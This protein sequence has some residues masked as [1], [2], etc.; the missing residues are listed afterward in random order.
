[1]GLLRFLWV[2]IL[3]ETCCGFLPQTAKR[4]LPNTLPLQRIRLASAANDSSARA[5]TTAWSQRQEQQGHARLELPLDIASQFKILTC[6][7]MSCA[8]KRTQLGLDEYSTFSAF[9]TRAQERAPTL[10]VEECPCLGRCRA[11]PCVAVEHEDYEGPVSL[12]GMT[13]T[14]FSNRVFQNVCWE[15]DADRVW[16]C[17]ENAIRV[18]AD[19]EE[20]QDDDDDM[21][22]YTTNQGVE[23]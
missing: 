23:V 11:G 16:D 14:E 20:Q 3:L 19:E 17:V 9:Y 12:D 22:G 5:T 13:S 10:T 2:W 1:M 15:E 4:I 8:Q 18:L 7:S 6:T 21:S